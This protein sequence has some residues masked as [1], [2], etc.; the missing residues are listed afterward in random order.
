MAERARRRERKA[1]RGHG[2]AEQHWA[3]IDITE[4]GVALS[5]LTDRAEAAEA[6]FVLKERFRELLRQAAIHEARVI[7]R[8][9]RARTAWYVVR[10]AAQRPHALK[11]EAA[12]GV[13]L[14]R[15]HALH[16][17]F[18]HARVIAPSGAAVHSNRRG[19]GGD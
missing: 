6:L 4:P 7:R 17:M 11:D 18:E 16:P 15:A 5:E 12:L 9:A 10:L 19:H 1:S 13:D 2:D 14:A 8:E 3:T